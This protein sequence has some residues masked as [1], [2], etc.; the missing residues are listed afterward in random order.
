MHTTSLVTDHPEVSRTDIITASG[1]DPDE[2][3]E[4]SDVM[5]D[6]VRLYG[7]DSDGDG[8]IDYVVSEEL[9]VEIAEE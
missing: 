1:I 8:N 9:D 3:G 2:D 7:I 4:L 5:V 6:G